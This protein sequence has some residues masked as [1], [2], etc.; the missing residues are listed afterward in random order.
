[1]YSEVFFNRERI[2]KITA[3]AMENLRELKS[4]LD[5]PDTTPE[6]RREIK[7]ALN[8]SFGPSK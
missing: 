1:M 8:K 7:I 4:K 6:E 3:Q 5:D 2:Q